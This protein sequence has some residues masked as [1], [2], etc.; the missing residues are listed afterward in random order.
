MNFIVA[1]RYN[2]AAA[3]GSFNCNNMKLH[4]WLPSNLKWYDVLT[5]KVIESD[6]DFGT[7]E[8]KVDAKIHAKIGTDTIGANTGLSVSYTSPKIKFGNGGDNMGNPEYYTY[9]DPINYTLEFQYYNFKIELL[10]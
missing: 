4:D 5:F 9:F 8:V 10:F 7:L 6:P 3:K 2:R 1:T